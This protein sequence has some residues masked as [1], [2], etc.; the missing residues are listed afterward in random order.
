[1]LKE[2][3]DS[4]ISP[5][6]SEEIHD[7]CELNEAHSQSEDIQYKQLLKK[8]RLRQLREIM[9]SDVFCF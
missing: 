5:F 4:L 9:I 7:S 6:D 8:R 2:V 3:D 1:M